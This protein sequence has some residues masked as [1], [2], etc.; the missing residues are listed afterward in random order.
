MLICFIINIFV[1]KFLAIMK[2]IELFFDSLKHNDVQNV[3]EKTKSFSRFSAY[4]D[5]LIST[6]Q[7]T[8]IKNFK[9]KHNVFAFVN[10][11]NIKRLI[12]K[13]KHFLENKS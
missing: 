5:D 1:S 2:I 8:L 4:N 3:I 12:S 9:S 7:N 10:I 6:K 13:N 11:R